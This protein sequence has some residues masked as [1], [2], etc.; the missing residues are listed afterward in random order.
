MASFINTLNTR[1]RGEPNNYCKCEGE[2]SADDLSGYLHPGRGG[3][4]LCA[5]LRPH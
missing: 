5:V 2:M 3:G 1:F 4:E